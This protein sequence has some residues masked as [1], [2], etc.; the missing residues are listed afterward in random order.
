M[1]DNVSSRIKT[2]IDGAGQS[3]KGA[4]EACGIP[5]RTMQDY[6]S[7]K[8]EPSARNLAKIAAGLRAD[9]GWLL[10]GRTI[11]S[12]SREECGEGYAYVPL[13]SGEISAGGGLVADTNIDSRLAFREDWLRRKGDPA[14]MSLIRV[15]GD[16]MEPTLY[17]GDLVLVDHNKTHVEMSGGIYAIQYDHGIAIKRLRLDYTTRRVQI[18]SDNAATYP[19]LETDEKDVIIN[20]K[21]IWFGRELER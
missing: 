1:Q 3:L 2:C 15:R 8:A 13:V 19:A 11:D 7:G 18:V 12:S 21:V 9:P 14:K 17:S 10:T 16:S 6:A 4:A 20:G 5:Y